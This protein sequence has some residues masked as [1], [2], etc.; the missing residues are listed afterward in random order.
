MILGL[1]IGVHIRGLPPEFLD[2]DGLLFNEFLELLVI[3]LQGI[4]LIGLQ[5]QLFNLN[6]KRVTI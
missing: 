3:G 6:F 1:Q 2:F 4:I 5:C